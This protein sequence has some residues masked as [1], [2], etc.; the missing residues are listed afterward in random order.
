MNLRFIARMDIKAPN[1]IKGVQLEGLRVIGDPSEYA[2]KYYEAGIDELIYMDVVAS[3]YERNGLEEIVKRTAEDIFIPIT[4]GGG[5]RSLSDVERMLKAGADK[6]ALNTAGIK[7]PN[8][9]TEIAKRF[10]SQCV[11]L[12]I[13]AKRNPQGNW[14]ALTDNGRE[15]T[16]KDAIQWAKEGE[17][18]GAGEILVTSVDQEGTAKGFDLKLAQTLDESISIPYTISGGMGDITDAHQLV[19]STNVDAIAM[20]HVLHYNKVNLSQ[21]RTAIKQKTE[22]YIREL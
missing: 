9:I 22:R 12:S 5:I 6:I 11:V 7:N 2:R 17:N 19:T 18:L 3:L 21:L 4:V 14:E 16:Y 1:L 8:L 20:A 13:E 10:G 15:H